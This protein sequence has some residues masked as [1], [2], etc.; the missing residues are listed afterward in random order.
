MLTINLRD[1]GKNIGPAVQYLE[2]RLDEEVKAKH[3]QVTLTHT[4][5]RV[6][7]VLLQKFLRQTRLEGHRILVVRP[8]LIEIRAPEKEK[9]HA[10]RFGE[11]ARPSA[12]ETV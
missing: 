6:A 3:S 4:T 2:S 5:T 1:L 7:K 11:G 10:V 8:G 12:W 9:R